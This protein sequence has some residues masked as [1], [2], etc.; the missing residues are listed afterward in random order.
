MT[1]E[2]MFELP[3]LRRRRQGDAALLAVRLEGGAALLRTA[4]GVDEVLP[5]VL[6]AEV[7]A[8]VGDEAAELLA[9]LAIALL[10]LGRQIDVDALGAI[11]GEIVA[12][13]LLDLA[14]IDDRA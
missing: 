10:F 11:L 13:Q 12:G 2:Q 3:Q 7:D 1:S 4:G 5:P 8:G 6:T 14:A 9:H